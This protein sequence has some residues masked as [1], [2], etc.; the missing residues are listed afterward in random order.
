MFVCSFHLCLEQSIFIF[1]AQIFKQSVRNQWAVSEQSES[2][3][4]A[5][6]EQSVS[7]Q[8]APWKH[9][10]STQQSIKIRVNTVGALNTASCLKLCL[11]CIQAILSQFKHTYFGENGGTLILAILGRYIQSDSSSIFSIGI[12]VYDLIIV[13]LRSRSSPGPFLLHSRS[14]LS[15]SNLF[16][17][18]IRW[19]GPGADAIFTVSPPTTHHPRNF[20]RAYEAPNQ[21]RVTSSHDIL[22]MLWR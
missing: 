5:V 19:S 20:S 14:I 17:F 16:Q 12:I 22:I 3:Q 7:S 9:L 15:H 4:W 10:E 18:K 6:S 8:W 11:K 21:Y 2:S 13:K 1:F